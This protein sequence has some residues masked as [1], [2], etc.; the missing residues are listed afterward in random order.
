MSVLR[1]SR[2]P[3]SDEV[4]KPRGSA[5]R[6]LRAF[7]R[8]GELMGRGVVSMFEAPQLKMQWIQ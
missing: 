6:L 5:I 2:S 7:S 1:S 3:A 8:R 4:G